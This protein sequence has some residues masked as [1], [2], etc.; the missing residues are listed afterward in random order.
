MSWVDE[1]RKNM[2]KEKGFCED[3]KLFI[4]CPWFC[5]I[6]KDENNNPTEPCFGKKSI[7]E[8]LT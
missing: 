4:Q 6:E 1:L 2:G 3:C 8:R 5:N 7:K